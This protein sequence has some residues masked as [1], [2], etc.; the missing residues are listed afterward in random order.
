[1][2]EIETNHV[3]PVE[4]KWS[5]REGG[6]DTQERLY[7]VDNDLIEFYVKECKNS[8]QESGRRAETVRMGE[9]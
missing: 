5:G 4:G 7:D 9:K 6:D 3:T 2:E 1:M 8:N